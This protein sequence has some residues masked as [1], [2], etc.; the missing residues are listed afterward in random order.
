MSLPKGVAVVPAIPD[1]P[2]EYS[3]KHPART[4]K[5][6]SSKKLILDPETVSSR[7]H[8][9][10]HELEHDTESVFWLLLYWAMVVQPKPLSK[11]VI[12]P[13]EAIDSAAWA[14]ITGDA[15]KR[16]AWSAH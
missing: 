3:L 1:S 2:D 12:W 10:R 11:K 5:F 8:Q 15:E 6:L 14:G 9:W 4:N 16:N 13:K 7:S